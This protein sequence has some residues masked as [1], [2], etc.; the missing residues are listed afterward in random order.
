MIYTSGST[1]KPK[2]VQVGHRGLTTMFHNHRTEIFER[3]E[4]K[5]GGRQL[6][7]A[8]TVSFSFDMSWEELFWMLAGHHLHVIDEAARADPISLV[9][10]YREVG[11]DVVN[12][13]PSY[14]RELIAGGL[15]DGD[16]A[17]GAHV[18]VLVMLGG[19]AV[20]QEL[21]TR[22]REQDGVDGYDLYGPTEFTINAMGSAVAESDTP[23]LGRPVRNACA[24]VLDT[25]L[26]PV[27]VGAAGELYMSGDG[28]AHGYRGRSGQTAS[29][30]VA[31]PYGTGERMYRTGDLVRYL[32]GAVSSTSAASTGRSRS[33]ASASSWGRS[34]RRSRHFPEWPAL[35][36]T[37]CRTG[38]SPGSS[39]TWWTA[40]RR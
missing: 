17:S 28:A 5:V 22:L 29:V 8:H 12:V 32:A 33:G 4:R 35:P 31:D 15:L 19:E 40:T 9:Q 18:P 37:C 1:G 30:F 34:S 20:P 25:G 21:W 3:T 24:R 36:P 14:A 23:C 7:I 11:I 10:H 26:R 39:G 16:V 38:P 6:R 27:A 2:G 13:T